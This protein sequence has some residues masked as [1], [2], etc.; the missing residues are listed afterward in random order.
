MQVAQIYLIPQN[1][2]L[3]W[4]C[5]FS[6]LMRNVVLVNCNIVK[7]WMCDTES[8]SPKQNHYL[9][10]SEFNS[11]QSQYHLFYMILL[12]KIT[13]FGPRKIQDFFK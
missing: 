13:L 5:F 3:L 6:S 9:H 12:L 8:E 1:I 10:F 7:F 2:S 4:L 11:I